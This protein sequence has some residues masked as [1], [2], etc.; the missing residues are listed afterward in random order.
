ILGLKH[1][2]RRF[3]FIAFAGDL[4]VR[5]EQFFVL[6]GQS[7]N[8]SSRSRNVSHVCKEQIFTPETNNFARHENGHNSPIQHRNSTILIAMAL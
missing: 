4:F 5:E 3:F 2:S 1:L 7:R 6:T 8:P